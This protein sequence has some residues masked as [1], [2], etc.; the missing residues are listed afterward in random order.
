VTY[1]TILVCLTTEAGAEQVL[2][3][4]C[5][6]ARAFD[7]HL[8]GIHTLQAI[9]PYPGIALHI[10]D[11]YFQ[12]F[13]DRM[14]AQNARIKE[15]FDSHTGIEP[16]VSEWRSIPAMSVRASD[17]VARA[18]FRADLVV[19]AQPDHDQERPDQH[20]VQK[21]LIVDS[22]RPVLLIPPLHGDAA[23]GSRIMIAWNATREAAAAAHAALPFLTAAQEAIILT[24]DAAQRHS[25]GSKQEGLDLAAML[26][27][28]GAK[29]DT[30]H[31]EQNEPSVGAQILHD[32]KKSGCDLIVMGGFGHARLH[33]L[34]FG[35]ATHFM[36]AKSDLPV[37]FSS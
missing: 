33:G 13:N 21:D 14:S 36:L 17:Q 9:V 3:A 18:A 30:K 22:G 11:P 12:Q 26:A 23:I 28:H 35:D 5:N 15:I 29:V 27:R 2:P 24:V 37:L 31:I 6:L 25:V 8:I 7:A 19:A 10:D 1:K 16:F 20:G 32:A 4:A 34:I